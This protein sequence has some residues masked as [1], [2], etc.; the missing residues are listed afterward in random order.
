LFIFSYP[1]HR[2]PPFCPDEKNWEAPPRCISEASHGP[3]EAAQ[4]PLPPDSAFFRLA[5]ADSAIERERKS[6]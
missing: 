4:R 2:H 1:G 5:D 6:F 3:Q